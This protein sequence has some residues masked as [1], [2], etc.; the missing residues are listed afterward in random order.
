MSLERKSARASSEWV[1][2]GRSAGGLLALVLLAA[3]CSSP[4]DYVRPDIELPPPTTVAVPPPASSDIP[5]P[6]GA[7]AVVIGDDVTTLVAQAPPGSTFIIEPGVHRPGPLV[8]KDGMTF[9]GRPGAVLSGAQV[10]EGF[11]PNGATWELAGVSLDETAHGEC[12]AGYG[13][14]ALRNDLF[15][16]DVMLWRADTPED[17]QPGEWWGNGD[18][19]VISGRSSAFTAN[20]RPSGPPST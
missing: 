4:A 15:I 8:P 1:G 9:L 13:A 16:D 10:L 18:R 20:A 11:E 19:V 6:A 5:T 14:C 12:V 3:G 17:L 7:I 2:S